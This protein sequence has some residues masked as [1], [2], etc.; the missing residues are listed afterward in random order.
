M[1]SCV[2]CL[3]LCFMSQD[4]GYIDSSR[5]AMVELIIRKVCEKDTSIIWKVLFRFARYSHV[6]GLALLFYVSLKDLDNMRSLAFLMFFT[7]YSAFEVLYR[8]TKWI[9]SFYLCYLIFNNY[10]YSLILPSLLEKGLL[11]NLE[12]H[13][14]KW[15]NLVSQ[16][17]YEE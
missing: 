8:K 13:L 10:Y 17:P 11:T 12:K 5:D 14:L 2:I 7:F 3:K 4:V 15:Y 16:E 9:L 6:I 1:I